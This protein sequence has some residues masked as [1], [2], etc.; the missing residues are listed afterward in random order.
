MLM[1]CSKAK[2]PSLYRRREAELLDRVERVTGHEYA[3]F[4]LFVRL[5]AYEET[6]IHL[7]R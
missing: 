3:L 2:D 1:L 5:Q 4:F 6:K 7:G